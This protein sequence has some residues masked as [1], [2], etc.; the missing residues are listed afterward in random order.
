MSLSMVSIGQEVVLK[1][2][3]WGFKMKKR[4]QEL[5][6]TPGVKVSVLSNDTNGAFI[7]NVRGS[8]LVV[9]GA[10]TQQIMVDFV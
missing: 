10:V 9:S 1:S 4:L 2:I 6:L 7:L 3:N 8:R 5:G